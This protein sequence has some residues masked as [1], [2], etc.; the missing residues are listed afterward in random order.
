MTK[1]YTFLLSIYLLTTVTAISQE[2]FDCNGRMFRVIEEHG[3]TFLQEV[4]IE[5]QTEEAEFEDIHFFERQKING[6]AYRPADNLIYGVLLEEPYVLCRID[7]NFQLERLTELPLPESLLFVSGDIS[8]DERYLVLFG[9]STKEEGNLLALVDLET[10]GYPTIIKP[11]AK[12]NPAESVYCAD[13]A[14]HPTLDKLY[15]F[16]H[17]EGRLITIDVNNALID[18]TSYPLIDPI[19]GNVPSIFFDS[20]GHLFGVGAEEWALSNRNLYQFDLEDGSA[21]LFQEMVYERNQDA[22]SCPFKVELL[23]RVSNRFA[24][25]CTRLDFEFTLLN[26]TDRAQI[27]LSFTDTF[28]EGSKIV[29]ISPLPFSGNITSGIGSNILAIE[30]IDLPIER[31]TFSV[32]IELP[33]GIPPTNIYNRA[34]LDGLLLSSLE[35][36]SY[37]YSD[38]PETAVIDD[39]TFFSI[40]SLSVSINEEAAAICPGDTLWLDAGVYG[41]MGYEW[42]NGATSP[43]I[44]VTEAG[45]YEVTVSTGCDEAEGS[46]YLQLSEIEIELGDNQII[47][48]GESLALTPSITSDAPIRS[49]FWQTSEGLSLDCYTCPEAVSF[50]DQPGH[51]QLTVENNWGCQASDQIQINIKGFKVYVPD[52]FSPNGDGNNDFFYLQSQNPYEIEVFRVF[53]RWGDLV[54]EAKNAFSNDRLAGWDGNFNG[55]PLPAGAFAWYANVRALNGRNHLLSGEVNMLK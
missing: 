15:G 55:K 32:S 50:P 38:D 6:I 36:P 35:E 27:D 25:P 11:L 7:A 37:I 5:L 54:F 30:D 47:E 21:H 10:P 53:N 28:P 40:H 2:P 52:A 33:E 44:A 26:R 45:H 17:S 24:F 18:N 31:Y 1:N 42:S 3:G 41:A 8:P 19:K 39:A 29:T 34:Y 4:H 22:C 43:T 20:F 46:T 12:S 23:N 48:I 16:E 14:F 51:Y 13:I 49:Y 9:F